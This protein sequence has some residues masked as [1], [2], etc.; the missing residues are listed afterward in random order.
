MAGPPPSPLNGSGRCQRPPAPKKSARFREEIDRFFVAISHLIYRHRIK[1]LFLLGLF[2]G[3]TGYQARNITVDTATESMLRDDDPSL[4]EYNQFRDQFGRSEIVVLLV[5]TP[6][7]F[8]R[9]FLEKLAAFQKALESRVPYLEK[10]TDLINIR[11]TWGENDT[12]YVDE[13]IGD[14]PP[15]DLAAIK[16]RALEN[17]L[18]PNYVL[19]GDKKSTV[20][21]IE[22][23]ARVANEKTTEGDAAPDLEGFEDEITTKNT[24]S[25]HYITADE[26]A[27]VN[28]AVVAVMKAFQSDDFRVTF[29]GGSVVVDVF[30]KATGTDTVRLVKIMMLV[31]VGFLFLLFRRISGV[32]IPII[33]VNA[34][35]ASTLGLMALTGTPLSIMTNILPAFLVSVGIADAVHL[36][37]IFYRNYQKTADKESAI[38]DAMGHSGLAIFMTSATTA[39]GLLSFTIAEIATI[40]DLGYFAAAG[41]TLAFIYTIILLPALISLIPIQIKPHKT[42]AARSGRMDHFLLFFSRVSTGHPRK[43]IGICLVFF[44]LSVYYIFQLHFSSFILTYFPKDHPVKIDLEQIEEETGGAVTF[45]IVVDT[46]KENGIVDPRILKSI[47]RLTPE[48]ESIKM[49]GIHVG[50]VISLADIVKE[51]HRALHQNDPAFYSIPDDKATIAQEL[52]LFE[53][54]KPDDIEKVVDSQ[55][56][57]TRITVKTRWSDSVIYEQ[58][59]RQLKKMFETEFDGQ[60]TITVT[61]LAALMGRTIPAALHSMARSYIVALVIITIL[62]LLLIGDLKLG[63]LSMCPNLLPI[64]MVMGLISLCGISLDI[65]T[66]FIGSI[67]IGLVVDDTIHFMHNF[68]KYLEKTGNPQK[69]IEATFLGTGRALLITSIV[70][71]MNFFVLLT[72]TLNHSVKFG[73]FTGIVIILALLSDFF[74]SPALLILATTSKDPVTGPSHSRSDAPGC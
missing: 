19:S 53:N 54:S 41:V 67:A 34:A 43:I 22:T 74:L 48:I 4:I 33:I 3:L 39:A 13:L 10:I 46:H 65:N 62:M 64:F 7:L 30:N 16:K 25:T 69:A 50:K 23:V 68:R 29:S 52:L 42:A 17:P 38:C 6:D 8:N 47:V 73:L 44:A 31:I 27:E 15:E 55:F 61:G 1:S 59:V 70:L 2:V 72:A 71:S 63:L 18:Y 9:D 58:F 28:K 26:K 37:A 12:L 40:A 35:M 36:L 24:G 14:P 21:I 66:L 20:L 51:T 49:D 56:S 32:I 11:H 5:E 45:E 60:A 57:K